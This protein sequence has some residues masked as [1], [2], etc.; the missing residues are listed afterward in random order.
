MFCIR[1][2][3][4]YPEMNGFH[5]SAARRVQTV[6]PHVFCVTVMNACQTG[7]WI[8]ESVAGCGDVRNCEPGGE[9]GCEISS[10]IA[11][12]HAAPFEMTRACDALA[13]GLYGHRLC[14]HV[15]HCHPRP[16][17]DAVA[18]DLCL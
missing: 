7:T 10:L 4:L 9:N 2:D 14:V 17:A 1:N 6:Y 13:V 3:W 15:S 5:E 8:V 12:G 11:P 18:S 16:S